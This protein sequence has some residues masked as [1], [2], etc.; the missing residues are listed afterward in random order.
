MSLSSAWAQLQVARA[1]VAATQQQ[2]RAAQLAFDGVREEARLGA[3]TTL[4][5]LDAEQE[6]LDA[7]NAVLNAQTSAYLAVYS[8]LQSMGLLTTEHLGLKV[9]RH[10]VTEYYNAVTGTA[11]GIVRSEQGRRLD[12]ILD[13]R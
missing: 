12:R 3:R 10:D 7:R 11:P 9:E 8:V 2:V 6:L 1:Q 4:D 5:V 13:R